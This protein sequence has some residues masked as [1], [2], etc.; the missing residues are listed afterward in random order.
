MSVVV[1][2]HGPVYLSACAP[3]GMA[4][5]DIERNVNMSHPTGISS[6]WALA[7]TP[8]ASGE[9]NPCP[10]NDDAGRLHYLLSC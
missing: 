1:Y 8:F 4:V 7:S 6:Q 5:A 2:S 3:A 10:C 9:P